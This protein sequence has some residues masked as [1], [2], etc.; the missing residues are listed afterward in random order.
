MTIKLIPIGKNE[1]NP[2]GKNNFILSNH[3]PYKFDISKYFNSIKE[4]NFKKVVLIIVRLI[5]VFIVLK[6]IYKLFTASDPTL[7]NTKQ[8][9]TYKNS[10]KLQTGDLVFSSYNNFLGYFMR[11]LTRSVWTHVGMIMKYKDKLYVMETADYSKTVNKQKDKYK[12]MKKYNGVIVVPFETWMSLNTNCKTSYLKLDTPV[13][14]DRRKL[15]QEFLKIQESGLDT[16][17]VGPSVWSKV[18]WK[19]QYQENK[20]P[21]NI[22]CSEMIVKIYQNADI[23]KKIYCPGSYSTKDIIEKKLEMVEGFNL[24]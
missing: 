13:N 24:N 23:M 9:L 16:F 17:G 18:L 10:K 4:L 19:K 14:W 8:L 20:L 2:I 6:F 15:I 7:T 21:S 5:T 3:L 12:D 1:I 22:T 11:G